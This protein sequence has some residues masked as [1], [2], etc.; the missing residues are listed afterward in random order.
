M[1]VTRRYGAVTIYYMWFIDVGIG[2]RI[3]VY[4]TN[5]VILSPD[6]VDDLGRYIPSGWEHEYLLFDADD[7][8]PPMLWLFDS[9][10]NLHYVSGYYV[11]AVLSTNRQ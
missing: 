7:G 6:A 1:N 11:E 8:I 5:V 3:R 4:D 10:F 2:R 9:D